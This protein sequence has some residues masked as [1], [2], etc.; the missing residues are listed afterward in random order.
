MSKK[1]QKFKKPIT[2]KRNKAKHFPTQEKKTIKKEAILAE[3]LKWGFLFFSLLIT[4][5]AYY[6]AI[7][8][9]WV[10]LDD[11]KYVYNNPKIN[12]L[13]GKSL[14]NLLTKPHDGNFHPLT[15]L[16]LAID[17]SID[18]HNPK[19]YHITNIS[20]HLLNTALIF[21][22]F[23][24]FGKQFFTK[25]Q[26][27]F[28]TVGALF[29]GVSTL[30]VESVAWVSERKDVLYALFYF[31]ALVAYVYYI[32]QKK[33]KFLILS[34]F[35]FVLSVLS[36]GMAV[37]LALSVVAIDYL[38]GRKLLNKK[39]LLEKLPFFVISF[40][41]GLLAIWAQKSKGYI[42]E[43][44]TYEIWK[45]IIYASYGFIH[46]IGKLIYPYSLSAIYP[47][48]RDLGLSDVPSIYPFYLLPT[49]LIAIA[50]F[51]F[52]KK[53]KHISFSIL[54]FTANLIFVLQ[55]IPV[56]GVIMSDRYSYVASV[57]FIYL[58]S[59]G[60]FYI[61]NKK[62]KLL[63]LVLGIASLYIILFSVK[64]YAQ[65]QVWKNDFSL[66]N[67]VLSLYPH[68]PSA[69]YN[70]AVA[71]Y[72][73]KDYTHSIECYDKAIEIA[74]QYIDAIYNRG[75]T[76]FFS[77][78]IK[79]AVEDY[80]KCIKQNPNHQKALYNRSIGLI[81]LRRYA[82]AEADCN[83]VLAET[84]NYPDALFNRGIARINLSK[85][86]LAIADFD[87]ILKLAPNYSKAILFKGVAQIR[88][89]KKKIACSNISTAM[90]LGVGEAK[91]FYNQYCLTK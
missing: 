14:I 48:P 30:H 67:R 80:N 69:W 39:V 11:D 72:D 53:N 41:F 33:S 43:E 1:K 15:M 2:K 73:Q 8:N 61:I 31:A 37:T 13:Q 54:F 74:P 63:A 47:Y 28:A 7:H 35:L 36:K 57:G 17:Y 60:I 25:Y 49:L 32:K 58:L 76:R 71:Y 51:Y 42:H 10:N 4:F 19:I 66:W 12:S 6:P 34:L 81:Q 45:R 38:Y 24:L 90:K 18:K 44:H 64:T 22:L 29:F 84:P 20:L 26:V 59:Y 62:E 85:N 77:G 9:Q 3:K 68:T 89:G 21:W 55:L 5:I 50:F 23:L 82:E 91:K 75:N 70:L 56:G 16:S 87:K 79:G 86:D 46:Y 40:I 78:D 65:T 83:K 52:W 27:L 88:K